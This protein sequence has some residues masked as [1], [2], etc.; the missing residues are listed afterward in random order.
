VSARPIALVQSGDAF[1]N[2]TRVLPLARACKTA[3]FEPVALIDDPGAAS[4][5]L[6]HDV[7]SLAVSDLPR[8][9]PF[10]DPGFEADAKDL[11]RLEALRRER[12][13]R[14]FDDKALA[15][16]LRSSRRIWQGLDRLGPAAVF[17]WNGYTGVWANALRTYKAARGLPGGFMERAPGADG[18]FVDPCGVNGDASIAD[19]SLRAAASLGDDDAQPRERENVLFVPLQ[20]HDDS[21]L[22]L[23]APG[24]TRMRDLVAF[25]LEIA[26]RLGGDWR[27][28]AR[29][30]PEEAPDARL[31]L[32]RD[33]RLSVDGET[34]LGDWLDRAKVCLT[35]NSAVG[36][37]AATH[38]AVTV[39]CGEGIYC[40]QSFVVDG[41]SGDVSMVAAALQ[42]R[43]AAGDPRAAARGFVARLAADHVFRTDEDARD[44]AARLA[45]LGVAPHPLA[46]TLGERTPRLIR[47]T[48]RYDEGTARLAAMRKNGAP[49]TVDYDFDLSDSLF[50]T[51]RLNR[52]PL[53]RAYLSERAS[54]LFG[55]EVR[56]SPVHRTV[57]STGR[58][59]MTAGKRRPK[60][61][62]AYALVLDEFGL[63]HARHYASG[64]FWPFG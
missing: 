18:V 19:G 15:G 2:R 41:R 24:I 47:R 11:C 3:G 26:V 1:E 55:R 33:A 35:V 32:P 34:P 37:Q 54:L 61:A 42:A 63:P 64:R 30:H 31:N 14:G 17:A 7:A 57:A 8:V 50:L 58:V 44:G 21:N 52:A 10:Y 20:V 4:L 59:L 40:Q 22:L 36:L 13:G 25:A 27:V 51:Y 43:F 56:L 53:S 12:Q 46:R 6:F 48:A 16:V 60:D 29:P 39:C 38:G 9:G 45:R 49:I 23:H 28:I 62:R 5:F